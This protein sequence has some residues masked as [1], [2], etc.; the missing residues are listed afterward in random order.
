MSISLGT[1]GLICSK[2]N[3]YYLFSLVLCDSVI[4]IYFYTPIEFVKG[5]HKFP[6]QV[7]SVWTQNWIALISNFPSYFTSQP[8]SIQSNSYASINCL[9]QSW[10]RSKT[11]ICAT[12][13]QDRKSCRNSLMPLSGGVDPN[14]IKKRDVGK[15]HQPTAP[16]MVQIKTKHTLN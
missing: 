9:L 1:R 8:H 10:T 11:A 7:C 16:K 3:M 12:I 6:K 2:M 15:Y 13:W 14:T 5:P 4:M